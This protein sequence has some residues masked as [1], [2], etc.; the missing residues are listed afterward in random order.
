M[1]PE[2][3][4]IEPDI[5]ASVP[6]AEQPYI[7][8]ATLTYELGDDQSNDDNTYGEEDFITLKKKQSPV[9]QKQHIDC[10]LRIFAK[11]ELA[12]PEG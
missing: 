1:S 10:M 8:Q 3:V 5:G 12:L 11:I 2:K 6:T 7:L 4:R 9:N